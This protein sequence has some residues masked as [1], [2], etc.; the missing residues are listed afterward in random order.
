MCKFQFSWDFSQ[1]GFTTK[2][3]IFFSFF[4]MPKALRVC[5]TDFQ[6][7]LSRAGQSKE[8]EKEDTGCQCAGFVLF[9]LKPTRWVNLG[10]SDFTDVLS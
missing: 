2:V 6:R 7:R 3:D 8:S 4:S 10:K 1:E 9:S 5:D